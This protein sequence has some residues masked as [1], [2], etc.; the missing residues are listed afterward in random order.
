MQAVEKTPDKVQAETQ[1]ER[2]NIAL[3]GGGSNC[4]SLIQFL[5]AH[6]LQHFHVSIVGVADPREDAP[7]LVYAKEMGIFTSGNYR[8]LFA[9]ENL[10]LII[11][12]TGRDDVLAELM[13]TK[14]EHVKVMDHVSA[15]LFREL[16]ELQGQKAKYERRLVRSDRLTSVGRMASY[17]AHEIRNPLVAIGGFAT[18][19]L[20]SPE[21]P[22]DLKSKAQIIVD[23]VRRLE[24]VLKSLG[25]YV[26]PLKQ[27]KSRN[28]Y[29]L[30]TEHVYR[31]L[32]SEGK[33]RGIEI[34][35]NLD[36]WMPDSFF[37]ADLISDV[38]LAVARRLMALMRSGQKLVLKTEVCWDS[39]GIYL[40]EDS[41]LISPAALEKM[42][43]PFSGHHSDH[44]ALAATMSKRIVDD[45]GGDI[46][47]ESEPGV[48][49]MVVIELPIDRE[50][51]VRECPQSSTN[52]SL[53]ETTG[54]SIE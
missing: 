6:R 3:V 16:M 31:V 48:R 33:S 10:H 50:L 37:D 45:H 38:L 24:Q 21:L 36:R 29:N 8:D 51:L 5:E 14:P 27:N 23:E 2:L 32:E 19:L 25:E 7:G 43:N 41:G 54:Q 28:N 53:N 34:T 4:K 17:L 30:V 52:Y 47:I 40:E 49:T 42:S 13:Q 20:E 44:A 1:S 9:L 15:R 11:E 39:V 35:L 46:K 18:I 12:I 22:D 26:R